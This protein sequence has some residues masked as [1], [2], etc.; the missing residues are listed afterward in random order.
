MFDA[1]YLAYATISALLVISP[2]AD[3]WPSSWRRRVE[4]GTGGG[5]VHGGRRQHRQLDA[6]AVVGARD[7]VRLHPLA[8][9]AAAR[10][11]RRGV[12]Y[13]T[14]LRR[15]GPLADRGAGRRTGWPRRRSHLR[16]APAAKATR[17]SAGCRRGRSRH[18]H[19]PAQPAG[20]AVLHDVP[21]AVH[22][23]RTT[24]S[25]PRFLRARRDPR[26][27]EPGVAVDVRGRARACW[28]SAWRAPACAGRWKA[29]TGR[30]AGRLRRE[31]P[32]S[33]RRGGVAS[34]SMRPRCSPS[35]LACSSA[36]PSASRGI[37]IAMSARTPAGC[38]SF[39]A[40][41]NRSALLFVNAIRMTVIP[42]VASGLIAGVAS[43][44]DAR[45][46]G[47]LGG[48]ALAV[49]VAVRHRRH[50]CSAPRLRLPAARRLARSTRRS[51][52][53]CA[54]GAA[55]GR[56]GS[57]RKRRASCRRWSQWLVD[58]VPV[59]ALKAASD[60]AILPLIVFSLAFGLA[61]TAVDR[62]AA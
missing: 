1:R 12:L 56:P 27:D 4:E 11:G 57:A 34:G 23:A 59:N 18:H 35:P 47:R 13:L 3:A 44:S 25:S 32:R 17:Q 39:R 53:R 37:G 28:P 7:V 29:L 54:A 16:A 52:K 6:R 43:M 10:E 19:E 9:D 36:S 20:G 50:A 45:A 30:P 46:V 5:A 40:W 62:R 49:F 15:R 38:A 60:G 42:L 61:L 58:L 33:V 55:R 41:S 21:A 31:A 26:L 24:R 14:W 2:G 22:R 8:V 51:P 48:R